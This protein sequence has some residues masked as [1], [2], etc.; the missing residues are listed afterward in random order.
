MKVGNNR[1]IYQLK[2]GGWGYRYT[3]TENGK[4]EWYTLSRVD[5]HPKI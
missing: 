3:Y 4:M 5:K 1:G 2:N